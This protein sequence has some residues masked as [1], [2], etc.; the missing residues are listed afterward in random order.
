MA[1]DF[2]WLSDR[3]RD[4]V[5]AHVG[6][7]AVD[8]ARVSLALET[9]RGGRQLGYHQAVFGV[10]TALALRDALNR[11]MD[12][13]SVQAVLARRDVLERQYALA[14]AE[15]DRLDAAIT[16]CDRALDAI[17]QARG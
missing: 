12:A 11:L 5:W 3:D 6:L 7:M 17:E 8:G 14:S 1:D 15:A 16:E 9:K 10:A 2:D 13:L 4:G